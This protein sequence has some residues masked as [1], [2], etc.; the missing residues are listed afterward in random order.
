[1]TSNN[2]KP[3]TT[4]KNK[5]FKNLIDSSKVFF[6][7][8]QTEIGTRFSTK[9]AD[10]KTKKLG[11]WLG[12]WILTTSYNLNLEPL[13]PCDSEPLKTVQ[14]SRSQIFFEIGSLKNFAI[15]T[16]KH[17]CWGFFLIKMQAFR[18][19]TFLKRDSNTNISC[20]YCEIFRS[21]FFWRTPPVAAS[22]NPIS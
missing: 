10:L 4:T 7:G 5:Q 17:L 6:L 8:F 2:L 13:D 18:P 20:G 11:L 19:A 16:G 12:S 14:S 22:E 1:M 3:S 15:F 9:D 21:S